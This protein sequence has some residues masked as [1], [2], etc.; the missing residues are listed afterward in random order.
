MP[1]KKLKKQP[2]KTKKLT[3]RDKHWTQGF[4]C[5]ARLAAEEDGPEMGQRICRQGGFSKQDLVEA[6]C[7]Q[8]DIDEIF[9]TGE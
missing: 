7:E 6:E 8:S 1:K 9:G 4:A 3:D 5:A 2:K